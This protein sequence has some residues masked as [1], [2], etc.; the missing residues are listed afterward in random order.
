MTT[1]CFKCPKC[2]YKV[3]QGVRD[4]APTCN[5]ADAQYFLSSALTTKQI[6][7]MS[8]EF[9]ELMNESVM[10][11]DYKAETVMIDKTAFREHADG[12]PANPGG[13]KK[14]LVSGNVPD[15]W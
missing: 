2:D 11:R 15:P 6:E 14:K 4:P 5:H 13:I 3:E 10:I 7:E 9:K 12:T 1:Y 8:D